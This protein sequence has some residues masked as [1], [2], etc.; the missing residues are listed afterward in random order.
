MYFCY[1][2]KHITSLQ[3]NLV[4]TIV[5][6][7][8]KS[9]ARKKEQL[10]VVEGKRE[11]MLALKGGYSLQNLLYVPERV[12]NA[13][14][15]AFSDVECISL[16]KEVYQKITYRES[17]EGI[18]ALVHSKPHTLDQLQFNTAN[19]LILVAEAIEKPGNVG[20]MLRTAD[21]AGIDAVILANPTSDIYNPNTIRSSVGG[22]FT[23]QIAVASTQEVIEYLHTNSFAIFAATLQNSNVYTYKNYEQ[24][25]AIVVGTE[26]T[27][28]S[29][30]WITEG[31]EAINIPMLGQVDSMN[32]SVA[33]AILLYEVKRQRNFK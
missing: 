25:T 2:M 29:D 23:N 20:A 4:K 31:I 33:A 15:S 3:N 12:D 17:T 24:A 14:L 28:L 6:L 5:R 26:A 13:Y 21:A 10:F 27:G 18:I 9:R 32:V 22:I 1:P 7:Q 30:A 11:V 8:E 16:D 19:P